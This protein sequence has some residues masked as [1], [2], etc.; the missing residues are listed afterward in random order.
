MLLVEPRRAR[1]AVM[2]G[3]LGDQQFAVE[4]AHSE[5]GALE[6]FWDT[7]PD[8]VVVCLGA[9]RGGAD[10]LDRLRAVCEPQL[11][12]VADA[13][14]STA[15]T[16]LNQGVADPV[17]FDWLPTRIRDVLRTCHSVDVATG[18]RSTVAEARHRAVESLDVDLA[19][20]RVLLNGKPVAL[21][22]TEFDVLAMLFARPGEV[23]S[24]CQLQES[25]WGLSWMGNRNNL[26]VH[27]GNLR[28]KLGDDPA[29]PRYVLTVRGV[30][31]RLR[32]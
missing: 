8:V 26:D 14:A 6:L 7:D 11:I 4:V 3:Y 25:L 29:R 22:R 24:R 5:G 2:A 19:A 9:R 32:L 27:V 18:G 30:G 17:V 1:A 12:V 21:T 20:R 10:V 13:D 16:T 23:V 15:A 28:R 31:F